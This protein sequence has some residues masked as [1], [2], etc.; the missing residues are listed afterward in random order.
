[1]SSK[2]TTPAIVLG[3]TVNGLGVVRS[4][5]R[6]GIKVYALDSDKSLVSLH[7]GYAK[8]LY[9]P[10]V[11]HNPGNF[12]DFLLNL[13]DTLG[14]KAILFPTGD[15]YNEFVNLYREELAPSLM[16]ALPS[17]EIMDKLLDKKGQYEL[18]R[19]AGVPIPETYFPKNDA[20]I[21]RI[22]PRLRYPVI[23]KGLKTRSWREK[24]GDKKAVVVDTKEDLLKAY[25]FL[26]NTDQIEPIIQEIIN[27]DDTRHFKICAYLD[28]ESRPLLTFTLQK[29][30]QYPCDFGIGS[31]VVSR[32]E[33]EVAYMGMKFLKAIKY[34]GVGS[35][36]F[37][38]DTRDNRLKMIEINPRFWAQNSLPDTCG[39]NFALTAYLD[40]LGE[41]LEP[42]TEFKEGV[43]WIA[44]NA[45][46]AS[47]KGYLKQ[48]RIT[49][50]KWLT[51]LFN[52][53]KIWAVWAFDDPLPFLF[54]I[55]FGLLPW[56]KIFGK[57][58]KFVTTQVS[59]PFDRS[60][61]EVSMEVIQTFEA[62][63]KLRQKWNALLEKSGII[64]PFLR[65][66]W[67]SAWWKG[68]GD[69][70]KLFILE[71]KQGAETIGLIP[72]MQYQT[73]LTGLSLEVMG[74]ISNYWT[75]MD[76][77]VSREHEQCLRQ[78]VGVIKKEKRLFLF[79]QIDGNSLALP[80]LIQTLAKE[81]LHFVLTKRSFSTL[82]LRDKWEDYLKF[83]SKSYRK[84]LN[85]NVKRL[86]R[87]GKIEVFHKNINE[88]EKIK[89]D[90][91]LIAQKGWQKGKGV[92]VYSSLA[93]QKFYHALSKSL[94]GNSTVEF[95]ILKVGD[96]P[97][98]YQIGLND[99][100]CY[101]ALETSYD[102]DYRD[103]S[104]G[105]IMHNLLLESLFTKQIKIFELGL[106]DHYKSRLAPENRIAWDIHIFPHTIFGK[107]LALLWS[108]KEKLKRKKQDD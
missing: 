66:E 41:H 62:F 9:C 38:R 73:R 50:G 70:K 47:F 40:I 91:D 88:F 28:R 75:R 48:K 34:W 17:Q 15:N 94:N 105:M 96:K 78:L 60:H 51:S 93:G 107:I 11:A 16:F 74:F 79:S 23:L 30:R 33:P 100:G 35:I 98:A 106:S 80:I 54:A 69:D 45:D 63:L 32:W 44:F 102:Q 99:G 20:E 27:G 1:M 103:Y 39:Q 25:Q 108:V 6:Q 81:G 14:G 26:K 29:I 7:T 42:Q 46:R 85:K 3:M 21:E 49:W 19:Q 10:D 4:L 65:H 86:M 77:V 36:E 87:I 71:F 52:G 18:A 37:K 95:S 13:T 67:L 82:F 53:S 22:S 68:Y 76:F 43:K 83:Q 5:A 57:I 72:L 92:G 90:L 55:K 101:Y 97:I 58:R 56:I 59:L 24:F 2:Y 31:C 104:P 84:D 61:K 8:C 64:N 12:K 89:I